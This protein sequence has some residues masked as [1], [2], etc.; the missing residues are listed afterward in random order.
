MFFFHFTLTGSPHTRI[1]HSAPHGPAPAP[2]HGPSGV[3]AG[4][5]PFIR[6]DYFP[7]TGH[8]SEIVK[9]GGLG[10]LA[11]ALLP[12]AVA[13]DVTWKLG[14]LGVE[15]APGIFRHIVGTTRWGIGKV[16]GA[17]TNL[18]ER[19]GRFIKRGTWDAAAAPIL[20]TVRNSAFSVLNWGVHLPADALKVP[21][22]VANGAIGL[23]QG[24]LSLP[25]GIVGRPLSWLGIKAPTK[26]S[27]QLWNNAKGNVKKLTDPLDNTLG[28]VQDLY[29]TGFDNV[30][31]SGEG[32]A[33]AYTGLLHEP[34]TN[35]YV[36]PTAASLANA[37][38]FWSVVFGSRQNM[39][40]KMQDSGI[41]RPLNYRGGGG[42]HSADHGA[43]HGG[44]GDHGGGHAEEHHD[45]GGGDHGEHH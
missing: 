15:H 21:G 10:N 40:S 3:P 20:R 41:F 34:W 43:A 16:F 30:I 18:L 8:V 45:A 19:G 31:A 1:Y 42:G 32:F 5:Y 13:A 17:G 44:G 29:Q 35:Q 39:H 33:S 6:P 12:S 25:L 9:G 14:Q 22:A 24:A 36:R 38:S 26:W 4:G 7:L 37:P 11:L 2:A 23:A 28:T 27:G